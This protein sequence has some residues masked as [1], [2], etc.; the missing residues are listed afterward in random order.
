MVFSRCK[1]C[2]DILVSIFLAI[3][4]L[5]QNRY[6]PKPRSVARVFLLVLYIYF[7]T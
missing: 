4:I 1:T 6:R 3:G 2:V 5:N 7:L